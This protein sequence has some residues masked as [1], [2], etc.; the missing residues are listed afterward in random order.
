MR[1]W[2]YQTNVDI[3]WHVA[4]EFGQSPNK[5]DAEMK[6]KHQIKLSTVNGGTYLLRS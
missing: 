5:L 4:L 3:I 6:L 2:I 1:V